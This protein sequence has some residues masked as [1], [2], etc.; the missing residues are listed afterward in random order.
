MGLEVREGGELSDTDTEDDVLSIFS[1]TLSNDSDSS[2]ETAI[3][4]N[5]HSAG[6]SVVVEVHV[7]ITQIL[8]RDWVVAGDEVYSSDGHNW[9]QP[10]I[11][12]Y[13]R[14]FTQQLWSNLCS[15]A[16]YEAI[17][18]S[19]TLVR[20]SSVKRGETLQE[21]DEKIGSIS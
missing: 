16:T 18:E 15:Q 2:V 7:Y 3:T 19:H 5:E 6:I 9:S 21:L 14:S 8:G 1:A 13:A 11:F 10:L 17:Y 4:E 12:R 20:L